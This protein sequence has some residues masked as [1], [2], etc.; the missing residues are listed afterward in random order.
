[1]PPANEA[2][3]MG[4]IDRAKREVMTH[5]EKLSES[6]ME[7]TVSH[8]EARGVLNQLIREMEKLNRALF[9]DNGKQALMLRV[10][11]IEDWMERHRKGC[12]DGTIGRWKFLAAIGA[13][14]VMAASAIVV[15]VLK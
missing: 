8:S 6:I 10:A 3:I 4:A 14:V 13:A 11:M 15:A 2:E 5:V 1:M 12:A 9:G 7:H